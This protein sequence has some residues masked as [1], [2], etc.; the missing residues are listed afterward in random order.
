MQACPHSGSVDSTQLL[1][2]LLP[3]VLAV[4]LLHEMSKGEASFWR[5]YLQ[6]LPRSYATAMC[7]RA[8]DVEALQVRGLIV[9]RWRCQ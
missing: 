4:H 1:L 9:R 8:A 5:P 6:S 7:F 3:Q 2:V